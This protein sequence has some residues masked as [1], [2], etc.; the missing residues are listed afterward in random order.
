MVCGAF[1]AFTVTSGPFSDGADEK[2]EALPVEG[3][4]VGLDVPE[5]G[6]EDRDLDVVVCEPERV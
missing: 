5:R 6:H 1:G 4:F 2:A 3:D